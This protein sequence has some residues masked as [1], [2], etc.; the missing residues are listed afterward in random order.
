MNLPYPRN[1]LWIVQTRS[2]GMRPA[3]PL[4]VVLNDST[5][6]WDNAIVYAD[7]DKSYRWDWIRGLPNV[8]VLIGAKT[9]MT[10]MLTDIEFGQPGQIDVIDT[11]RKLGWMLHFTKPYL[12]TRMWSKALVEDWLGDCSWHFDLEQIKAKSTQQVAAKR[13]QQTYDQEPV[14]T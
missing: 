12:K 10:T 6:K 11:D 3:G 7:P 4:I 2:N 13:S 5:P 14:W 9:R 8:V 1:A